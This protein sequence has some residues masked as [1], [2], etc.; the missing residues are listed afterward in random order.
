MQTATRAVLPGDNSSQSS[1]VRLHVFR[2]KRYGFCEPDP[3]VPSG[4]GYSIPNLLDSVL[5]AHPLPGNCVSERNGYR[6][7]ESGDQPIV[8]LAWYFPN[9]AAEGLP[10][11]W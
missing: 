5:C 2:G 9:A 10:S 1:G 11:C 4:I 8:K 7:A 6:A 3:T